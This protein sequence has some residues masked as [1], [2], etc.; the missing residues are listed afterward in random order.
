MTDSPSSAR[1]WRACT[2]GSSASALFEQAG[3]LATDDVGELVDAAALLASQPLPAGP[4]VAVVSNAGGAGVLAADACADAGLTVPLLGPAT[5]RRLSAALPAYAAVGNPVDTTAAVSAELF[6]SALDA[7][8]PA[9]R[10][11]QTQRS[12]P[13]GRSVLRRAASGFRRAE[14]PCSSGLSPLTWPG[15]IER[16]SK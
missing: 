7:V 6:R 3:I 9:G 4:R 2:C 5:R 10:T 16:G 14:G 1:V 13:A 8:A 15:S 12:R 11:A